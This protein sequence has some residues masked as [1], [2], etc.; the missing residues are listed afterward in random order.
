MIFLKSYFVNVTPDIDLLPITSD[1]R[2]AVRD[3]GGKNGLVT[4]MIPG[5]G[6]AVTVLEPL[7]EVIEELKI[8]LEIFAGEGAQCKDKKKEQVFIGPR[9]QAAMIGRSI[10]LPITESRI[11]MEP[12]EEI[13]LIDLDKRTRRREFLVQVFSEESPPAGPQGAARGAPPKKK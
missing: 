1:V 2:Y 3:A 4:I 5:S 10:T 9:V 7:P 6:A 8:A 11:A 12:Y 13:Y